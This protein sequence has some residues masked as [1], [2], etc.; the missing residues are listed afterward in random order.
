MKKIM[1]LA[2]LFITA[3]ILNA[4]EEG[5]VLGKKGEIYKAGPNRTLDLKDE[6]TLEA[7]IKADPME[8][9]GGR[10]MDKSVR[11]TSE[12]YMLDTF[13]GNSL[14]FL[15]LNGA[16][17]F[18]ANL[19]AD[20]WTHVAGV[21]SASKKI[22]KLYMDG[23][24]VASKGGEFPTMS[25]TLV[26]LC[27]GA[28]P[29]GGDRFLGRIRRAAVYGRALPAEEIAKRAVE[30]VKLE[31]VIGEW[32]FDEKPGDKITPV[33][34][35]LAL[36]TGSAPMGE[37]T[38]E[39]K[40]PSEP[41]C[42][43]YNRPAAK[44]CEAL[45][46]GNGKLGAMVFGGAMSEHIQFNEGTIWTGSPHSYVHEGAVKFLPE[47]RKLLQ[48]SRGFEAEALK[49]KAEAAKLEAEGKQQEAREKSKLANEQQKQARAKQKEAED[50]AGREFMSVPLRQKAYQPCGDLFIDFP[51]HAKVSDY[52][53]M[54]NLDTAVVE[55]TYKVDG[56]TFRR[57]VFASHPDNAIIV[58]LTADK[59]GRIECLARMASAHK[60]HA[61][62]NDG[63][64]GITLTGRVEPDG[65]CFEAR[66]RLVVEGGKVTAGEDGIDI[67]GAD[68]VTIRLVAA[69]NVKNFRDISTDPKSSCD[70]TLKVSDGKS[71]DQIKQVHVADHQSLFRRVSLDLGRT[72]AVNDPTDKRVIEFANRNDAH[73]AALVFQYGRY[74]MI[75]CGRSGSQPATLQGI[76]NDLLSPPWD[77]KMTCNINTEMN[78]WPVEVA[79]L[80]E[81]HTSLFDALDDLVISGRET[82]K[83]HYNA[84]G[85]VVHHNFDMWRGSAP[86]NAS[87]HGI[88][89]TG[90]GWMATHLWEHFL[91]TRDMDFLRNRAYP[92]LKEAALFYADFLYEDEKTKWLI[93]GPS[94]SPE[95]GGLVMGPTMDHQIIRSLFGHVIEAARL[96]GV[97]ADL[98]AKLEDMRKRIAPN[99]VGKHGQLQEWLEDKDDPK[100]QHRHV[101]HLWGVYPGYDVNWQTP[102]FFDA[103][104]QS[105][106]YRGDQATGWSMGWKI[107]L[108]A[109]FL[110]GDH[111]YIILRNLLGPPGR[112][113][114]G[115]YPNLFDAHPP[116]Q[117]DG[118]FG[119]C[120]GIAEMMVQSHMRDGD[121]HIVHLLPALPGVWPNG[122]VKGLKARG[123]FEVDIKWKDGKLAKAEIKSLLGN[124][125]K[126]RYGDKIREVNI[127]KGK[128]FHW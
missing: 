9:G 22:M 61:V 89:V 14:R 98:A 6:V 17:C 96:L 108:W 113:G 72:D 65:V 83:V 31:G 121:Q 35:M 38:G 74:L 47:I 70:E 81:C 51:D 115:L 7:W 37:F 48:E 128:T 119:A 67:N 76:W 10:I 103:A 27:I 100:N 106:I 53:R 1:L 52:R 58:R 86:I 26:P 20:K 36:L 11:G 82:A 5:L 33:A 24:E 120:A 101:S 19:S 45:P 116:F 29:E 59:P 125:C 68:A 84:R 85:W 56:V 42:L 77:S 50:L 66:A 13:P 49:L 91:F 123:G 109:R 8:Q 25:R 102:K 87:N 64:A 93:S 71:F 30:S 79:N 4:K 107:N 46:V 90:S 15:N 73:L 69:S 88:W 55:T 63:T 110:D 75:A 40:P 44:W 124:P 3:G 28:N 118:N 2:C 114:G 41:W 126:V 94:N 60:D 105:L 54:L 78:Y 127:K 111:A 112:G 21:Y 12:G 122:S 32:I 18:K 92:I 43:W 104:K 16:C 117:I 23:K 39:A 62:K 34:G 97:D 99:L 95:Q 57:E 80:S